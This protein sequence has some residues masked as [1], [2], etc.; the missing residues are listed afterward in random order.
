MVSRELHLSDAPSGM[1]GEP[2]TEPK[3]LVPAWPACDRIGSELARVV[4]NAQQHHTNYITV[5]N[6]LLED[7][8]N[9]VSPRPLVMSLDSPLSPPQNSSF[10]IYDCKSTPSSMEIFRSVLPPGAT[11]LSS[12]LITSTLIPAFGPN[13]D[14]SN[15]KATLRKPLAVVEI[16]GLILSHCNIFTRG[17]AYRDP[18]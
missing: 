5:P 6:D 18:P 16:C 4:R 10:H 14:A 9:N 8:F 7:P 2:R 3:P 12:R 13:M 1:T 17:R 11:S 15:T